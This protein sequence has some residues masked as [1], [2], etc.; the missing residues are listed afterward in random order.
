MTDKDPRRSPIEWFVHICLVVLF[1]AVA[2]SLAMELLAQIWPWL[3][4][5]ALIAIAIWAGINWWQSRR[6]QW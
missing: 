5:I 1:G 2:L 3:C 4:L 6:Q